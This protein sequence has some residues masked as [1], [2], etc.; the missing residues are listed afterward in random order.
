M[1][2][3]WWWMWRLACFFVFVFPGFPPLKRHA[4]ERGCRDIHQRKFA[5]STTNF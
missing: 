5:V 3:I 4:P 1:K 2:G